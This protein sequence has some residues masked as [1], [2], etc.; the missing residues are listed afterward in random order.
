MPDFI[1]SEKI[2]SSI[3]E[4]YR[5]TSNSFLR[6][7]ILRTKAYN[8]S[9]EREKEFLKKLALVE[10]LENQIRNNVDEDRRITN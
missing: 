5:K 8:E 7:D 6:T 3:K 10:E 1:A 9:V 2:S 4:F